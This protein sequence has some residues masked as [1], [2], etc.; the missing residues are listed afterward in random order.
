MKAIFEPKSVAVIGA[1]ADSHK[2]G[3]G[4]LKNLKDGGFFMTHFNQPFRGEIF[5]VNLEEKEILGLKCYKSITQIKSAVDL[6]VISV[7]AKIVLPVVKDCAKKRVKGI[8][9]I[10]AGFAELGQEGKKLQDSIVDVVRK[11]KIP[12]IGPNCLGVINTHASLNA[13]FAPVMPPKGDIAFVSQSGALADSV[14]DWAIENR[15]GFSKVISY[16]NSADV[17]VN[18]IIEFLSDDKE[19]KAIAV[20]IEGVSDGRR[21]MQVAKK[22]KKPIIVIKAGRSEVG[23]KA[24]G[25]HTGSLA[26]SF[27]VYRAAFRQSKIFYAETL[28]ELFDSAWML[29][30]QPKLKK[31][32]IAIVTNGGGCGVLAADYCE[33]SGLNLAEVSDPVFKKIDSK[34][35]PAYSRRNPL[36]LVGDALP[37]RYEAAINALLSD[38]SVQ[39]MVVIE[40]L[41]TMTKPVENAKVIV[42]ARKRFPNKPIVCAFMGGKFTREGKMY[43]EAHG[44]PVFSDLERAIRNLK[45]LSDF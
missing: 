42:A 21:F 41:Q 26:G 37:A 24:I 29:S 33:I 38:N 18:D 30:T 4:V 6:A 17:D 11:A 19:T 5:P 20:Y 36:D 35:H 14:L 8:I 9:I 16:G 25:S 40:T 34:M 2:V 13:T 3:Y 1:S 28:Q 7:P 31:N 22:C 12:L 39:G 45:V 27:E 23:M 10:S 44:I 32:S 43:L 15:Y